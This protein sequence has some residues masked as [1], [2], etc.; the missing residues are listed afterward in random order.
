MITQFAQ[1]HTSIHP[2]LNTYLSDL[3]S[4]T[5]HHPELDGSLLTLQA[6]RDADDLVR[7]F[8]VIG[9]DTLGTELIET[10]ANRAPSLRHTSS[11]DS[12]D[13]VSR[14]D[15]ESI[16][17]SKED[18]DIVM[19]FE[20]PHPEVRVQ[21]EPDTPRPNG[22]GHFTS[23][24]LGSDSQTRA[25]SS[26]PLPPAEAVWDVSEADIARIFPRVVSHRSSVR[27]G[28]DDEILGS[29]M[30]PAVPHDM[31]KFEARASVV[32]I[33]EEPAPFMRRSVKE[34]LVGILADV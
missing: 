8:R 17:W 10:Y 24:Q 2:S 19:T 21:Q 3:F 15:V 14:M 28:P 34:I 18:R 4:A 6:R 20:S 33:G 22:N 1:A 31:Q 25:A 11:T 30:F 16:G 7:A 12:Y 23:A 26:L 13:R 27:G 29:V 9:G 32:M 5:R